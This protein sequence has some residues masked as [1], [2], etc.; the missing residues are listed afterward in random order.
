M[1]TASQESA[2]PAL[3]FE[4]LQ[5]GQR[6]VTGSRRIEEA[7]IVAFASEFD[8]QPFHVDSEAAK[9]SFFGG[10]VASGWHTAGITMRLLVES[11]IP[12]AGGLIGAGVEI[13]WPKPTPPGTT[14]HVESEVM[15]VRRL[16]SRSDRGMAIVRNETR[17]ERGEIVQVMITKM[18]VPRRSAD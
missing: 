15:E 7:E 9:N 5:V 4:D 13:A 18:F 17:D 12:I 16:R 3:Y 8:P 2:R 11:G 6:F 14:V 1:E 10:L